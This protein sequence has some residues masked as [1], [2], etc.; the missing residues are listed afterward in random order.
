MIFTMR[1]GFTLV[2]LIVVIA[3]LGILSAIAIPRFA[4]MSGK[5]RRS[6]VK[7]LAG[8]VSSAA[9]IAHG[10]WLLAPSETVL[11]EGKKIK[12]YNGTKS[13]GYPS[14]SNGGINNAVNFNPEKFVFSAGSDNDNSANAKFTMQSNCYVEY[15]LNSV[16]FTVKTVV[17]GCK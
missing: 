11:I 1:K 7:A 9:T 6:A 5:A 10:K 8:A 14:E 16:N 17:S 4:N 12:I 13:P 2:E 3:I 15:S